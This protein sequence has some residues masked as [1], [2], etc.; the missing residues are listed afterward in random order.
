VRSLGGQSAATHGCMY[1]HI[2]NCDTAAAQGCTHRQRAGSP[3]HRCRALTDPSVGYRCSTLPPLTFTMLQTA[4]GIVTPAIDS[5]HDDDS[6]ALTTQVQVHAQSLTGDHLIS[7]LAVSPDVGGLP[8]I[9][10]VRNCAGGNQRAG[11][12]RR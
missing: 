5:D 2:S 9:A 6:G 1:A 10:L 12:G 4:L 3:R 8:Y 7:G 11:S